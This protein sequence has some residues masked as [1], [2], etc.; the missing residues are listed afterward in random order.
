MNITPYFSGKIAKRIEKPMIGI[1]LMKT[2]KAVDEIAIRFSITTQKMV[3]GT[4][5]IRNACNL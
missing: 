2:A 4:I 5:I 3:I 1:I